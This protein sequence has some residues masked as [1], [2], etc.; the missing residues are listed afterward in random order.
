MSFKSLTKSK[1]LRKMEEL[2]I[3]LTESE[4]TLNAIR[5][6]EIDAIVV[7]GSNGEKVFSLTSAETPYRIL[8]EEMEEGA[9]IISE[10]GLILYC[11]RRFAKLFSVPKEQIMG[12]NFSRFI[13]DK[14]KEK[15]EMLLNAGLKGRIKGETIYLCHKD[16]LIYLHLSFCA[17]PQGMPGKVCII[18]TDITELK[19]YEHNLKEM[20]DERTTDLEKANQQLKE[21]NATKDKLL[22]VI[23]HDLKGPVATLLGFSDLLIENME[24]YDIEKFKTI[25]LHINS[26]AKNA[27]TLLENLLLWAMSQNKQL[28]F[29]PANI[30]L[31]A[32]LEDVTNN[33]KSL[34]AM[35]HISL[36]FLPARDVIGSADENMVRAIFRNLLANA[37]KFTP[38]GGKIDVNIL[39]HEREVEIT[40]TDNGIG[41]S[42]ETKNNLFT[43][44]SNM[45]LEGTAHERGTGLGLLI[46][47]EFVKKHNGKISVASWLGKG[48]KF[49]VKLP[50]KKIAFPK[51]IN[52]VGSDHINN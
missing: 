45:T 29:N 42:E 50:R 20:V 21:I 5:N 4:E 41:M 18:V 38:K 33:F 52:A 23:A 22:S 24:D 46:C 11:N 1:L 48:S 15:Y 13:N 2:Q 16:N 31:K 10:T 34:A 36:N 40:V 9:V 37:I 47:Y 3:R 6:G 17:L 8:I 32:T 49:T 7:S 26:A 12:S 27:L 30:N 51:S 19:K 39:Q 25:V 44:S 14:E 35:K 28:Q 43:V